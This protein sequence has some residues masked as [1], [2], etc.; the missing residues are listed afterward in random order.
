MWNNLGYCNWTS[1]ISEV[2]WKLS[3]ITWVR[4]A[5]KYGERGQGYMNINSGNFIIGMDLLSDWRSSDFRLN[6]DQTRLNLIGD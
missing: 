1:N 4:I 5:F 6:S 3:D 2:R